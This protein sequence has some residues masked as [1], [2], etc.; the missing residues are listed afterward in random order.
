MTYLTKRQ[1]PYL[2]KLILFSYPLKVYVCNENSLQGRRINMMEAL[3]QVG[4]KSDDKVASLP[5]R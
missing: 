2:R 4:D 5:K 3:A 1:K